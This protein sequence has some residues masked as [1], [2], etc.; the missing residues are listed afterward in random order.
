MK[1]EPKTAPTPSESMDSPR[2]NRHPSSCIP[3]CSDRTSRRG[4]TFTEVLFAV[5]IL[6][7]GFIMIAG[8]FPVA[9]SQTASSQEETVGA[10]AARSAVAA[11][12]SMP[13]LTQIVQN[14]GMARRL[15][16]DDVTVTTA[17]G[18]VTLKPWS[19]VKGNQILPDEP[20]FGWVALIKREAADARGQAPSTAQLIVIP[21]QVRGQSNFTNNDRKQTGSGASAEANLMPYEVQVAMTDQ[22][23]NPDQC[24]VTGTFAEAAAPGAVIIL[25]NGKTYRLGELVDGSTTNYQMLPGNDLNGSGENYTGQAFIVGRGKTNG[26]FQGP[27]MAI[28][29][30]ITYITLR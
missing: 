10:S 26:T 13:Y 11:Y 18:P 25:S 30:Y 14:D 16:D 5:M 3:G 22:G 8:V 28:G 23:N 2:F 6:G 27:S 20:R 21:V 9:I 17:G 4:F 19:L 24:T 1:I 29:A 7:I 12:G 15:T